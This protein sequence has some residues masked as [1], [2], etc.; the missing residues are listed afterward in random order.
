ML[1]LNCKAIFE[2]YFIILGHL[3]NEKSLVNILKRLHNQVTSPEQRIKEAA[4]ASDASNN[5]T[6]TRRRH[7]RQ[8]GIR[9]VS[10]T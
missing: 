4:A 8:L 3:E 5:G 6:K 9:C 1:I 7:R 2:V 10:T